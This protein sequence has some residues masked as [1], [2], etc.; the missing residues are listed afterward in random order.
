MTV[1]VF[2]FISILVVF[3][4]L[5]F[6]VFERTKIFPDVDDHDILNRRSTA[7]NAKYGII[8]RIILYA[9]F[10]VVSMSAIWTARTYIYP[11]KK[12]GDGKNEMFTN[13]RYHVLS[14]NGY[15]LGDQFYLA[16]GITNSSA[17]FPNEA[18]WDSKDGEVELIRKDSCMLITQFIDPIYFRQAQPKKWYEKIQWKKEKNA[19]VLQNQVIKEDVSNGFE[20]WQDGKLRYVLEIQ[21]YKPSVIDRLFADDERLKEEQYFYISRLYKSDHE[22][23]RDTSSFNKIIQ[24]GYPL[25]DII[26]R[27]PK[28]DVDEDIERWFTGSYL[29][30]TKIP[31][32]GNR[33]GFDKKHPAPLCLMPGLSFYLQDGISINNSEYDFDTTFRVPFKEYAQDNKVRFFSG[34]GTRQSEEFCLSYQDSTH[35]FLELRQHHMRQLREMDGRVF[36]TSSTD[37]IAKDAREGGYLYNKFSDNKNL[38]HIN[39]NIRYKVGTARDSLCF[40]V[41]DINDQLTGERHVYH[42][43]EPF[44]LKTCNK[45]KNAI[46]WVPA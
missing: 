31:L 38:N 3:L 36:I 5:A 8:A 28:I 42:S 43:D 24:H 41:L 30:R 18:L 27:S 21:H 9:L 4:L 17:G 34:L 32:K 10:V 7:R 14:H 23:I 33:F 19:Y 1:K 6:C 15:L 25:M 40:A 20:L 46:Q 13:V 44:Y 35:M 45:T 26:A 39:A 16:R 11:N 29:V 37:E 2:L 12:P 22:C